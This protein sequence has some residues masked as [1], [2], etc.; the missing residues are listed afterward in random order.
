MAMEVDLEFGKEREEKGE[1]GEEEWGFCVA[2]AVPPTA[3]SHSL[4]ASFSSVD[5]FSFLFF[6]FL[7]FF[8]FFLI[9][10]CRTQFDC[11]QM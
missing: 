2:T 8:F 4:V 1:E 7:D 6:S 3:I 11:L 5:G 10:F 9:F